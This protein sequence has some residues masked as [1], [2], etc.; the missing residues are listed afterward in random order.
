MNLVL[1][2]S[3]YFNPKLRTELA[4]LEG[5]RACPTEAVGGVL[6]YFEFCNTLKDPNHEEHL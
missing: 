1:E 4:C 6:G 3:S 5:E 2:E